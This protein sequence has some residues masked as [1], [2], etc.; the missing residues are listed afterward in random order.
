MRNILYI[1]LFLPILTAAQI[2]PQQTRGEVYKAYAS[3]PSENLRENTLEVKKTMY[4][5]RFK[6]R[7]LPELYKN[8]IAIYFKKRFKA[9]ENFGFYRLKI[10]N[11][12][13]YIWVEGFKTLAVDSR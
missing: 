9:K 5:L 4:G 7:D 12:E 8:A 2:S 10:A 6:D 1:L 11:R 13:G 3:K